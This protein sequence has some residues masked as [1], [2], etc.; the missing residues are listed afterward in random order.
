M[1]AN[2]GSRLLKIPRLK[3]ETEF[4]LKIGDGPLDLLRVVDFAGT[5]AVSAGFHLH[6]TL[7]ST[8]PRIPFDAV[9]GRPGLFTFRGPGGNRFLHGMVKVFR[10]VG[11]KGQFTLYQA[12]LV[13]AIER[14][15]YRAASRIF[16][17]KSI[18]EILRQVL[19][20]GG[21]PSD[22]YRFSLKKSYEPREYVVQYRES[23]LSFLHRLM[24]QYGIF[25][26]FE[27]TEEK[28]IMVIGDDPVVHL[29]I[30]GASTVIFRPPGVTGLSDEEHLYDY[31]YSYEIRSEGVLLR[32]FDFKKPRVDLSV[33]ARV[34]E[35]GGN[36]RLMVYD[37]PGEYRAPVE[38]SELARVRLEALQATRELGEGGSDCRRL[39]AG[40]R[41]LLDR[42]DRDELNREYLILSVSHTGSQPQVLEEEA[43]KEAGG[44]Y[45][46]RFQCIPSETPY[47]P[48]L[49]P[50][51]PSI[52]GLQTATVVGP[53]GEEI[54]TDE[55]GRIKIQF[56]WDRE[57]KKDEKSSCW[58]RVKQ[59]WAG[60]GWG[61][62]FLPR[63]GHEVV[64]EFEEGNPDRPL[65]TG[66][67]YNGENLPPYP[68]PAEKTKSTIKTQSSKG[69]GFNELRFEDAKDREEIYLHG[70][71]DLNVAIENDKTQKIGHDET[72]EVTNNR[73]KKIG[74]DQSEEVGENQTI[75]VGK[76]HIERIGENATIEVGKETRI[77]IGQNMIL[78]VGESV[79]TSIGGKGTVQVKEGGTVQVGDSL[80]VFAG[81]TIQLKGPDQIILQSDQKVIV[82]ADRIE[83]RATGEIILNGRKIVLDASGDVV[84]KGKKITSN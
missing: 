22:Q 17:Y 83:F 25:F 51:R 11:R 58:V 12:E 48:P 33:D 84:V 6:L 54:Y 15:S 55:Y 28:H 47:R 30:S 14:L 80:R 52:P 26:L 38:G 18:P 79:Q 69:Q 8:D 65:V 36:G 37:Y 45:Q 77:Q 21:I 2:K 40:Y 39:I 13:P 7:A 24:V 73:K 66:S 32:D 1:L 49:P 62:L 16:Q 61:T 35:G 78:S 31:S 27:H 10:Q 34:D 75:T 29:P 76:D 70:Q 82:E 44:R 64:V 43:G 3:S 81:T 71:K 9:V 63:V 74:K 59:T 60:N 53:E 4:T 23:D 50:T 68:L 72:L 57:G 41:F 56:H 46:N 20:D 19:N 5:E 67:V 42:H